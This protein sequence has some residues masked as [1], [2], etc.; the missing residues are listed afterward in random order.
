MLDGAA[1]R[2]GGG[3]RIGE[4]RDG[5]DRAQR[6]RRAR[7][8][9]DCGEHGLVRLI[10]LGRRAAD[11]GADVGCLHGHRR[12]EQDDDGVDARVG[13]DHGQGRVEVLR[14][15]GAEHVDGVRD[16][17]LGRKRGGEGRT[18][19]LAELRKLQSGSLAGVCAEDP[20]PTGIREHRDPP[21]PGDGL[22]G[23]QGGDVEQAREGVGTNHAGL[24]EDGV[25]GG[26]RTG[27]GG[28][29]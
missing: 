25:D 2:A 20:Q 18:R 22:A 28:S 19:F 3:L 15:G 8:G 27:E 9:E 14:R 26:V 10:G 13:E 1:E 16:R 6:C 7:R 17:R 11:R 21:A 23:E 5:G 29:V 4:R 24:A 12:H